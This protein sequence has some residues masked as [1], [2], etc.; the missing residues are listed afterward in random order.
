MASI[1]RLLRPETVASTHVGL[2]SPDSGNCRHGLSQV[3][4]KM[5]ELL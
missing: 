2:P 3:S 4:G 1:L 5:K